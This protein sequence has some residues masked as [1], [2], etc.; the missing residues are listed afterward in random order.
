MTVHTWNLFGAVL[1]FLQVSP[2]V[3]ISR[4]GSYSTNAGGTTSF[5]SSDI[6]LDMS[7][8]SDAAY[9][10]RNKVT[11]CTDPQAKNK[12]L[13]STTWQTFLGASVT[14]EAKEAIQNK[15]QNMSRMKYA[16]ENL[17]DLLLPNGSTC[18]HYSHD[19]DRG[20]QVL[21]VRSSIH[22]Y[23]SVVYAGTDD[24]TTALMDGDILMSKF[25]PT[26]NTT[27]S[28]IDELKNNS[29][30]SRLF[31]QVPEEAHVHRGFNSA[32]FDSNHFTEVLECVTS[33]RLGGTCYG[34][35]EKIE[36]QTLLTKTKPYQL[37]TTGHSLGAADS[38]LL[39]AAL[40]LVFPSEKI[41][42]I[43]FGCPKIGNL[44]MSYWM[45]SL[46]PG[47]NDNDGGLEIFRFVNKLDLVPR[48]PD[49]IFFQHA[50]HTL[51]MS[52]GGVIR[53]YYNHIG[54]E[55][56]GYA[57]VSFGWGTEPYVLFPLALYAHHHK[58]YVDYLQDNA[59]KPDSSLAQQNSSYFVAEFERIDEVTDTGGSPI[60]E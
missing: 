58:R 30:F 33:A 35:A 25:G 3:S 13:V 46:Q 11:S 39:G 10:L 37:Y 4:L 49:L 15:Q 8:L 59:P 23:V 44:E 48:L 26:T 56:L 45:D 53:A 29:D 42:S 2:V 18:L 41:Q 57:G 60:A 22:R 40:H 27:S 34:A 32:V 28:D 51:Q 5:P 47:Q 14:D 24:F 36:R 38:I 20:T 16:Q 54:D 31:E 19:Y 50:G 7:T 17:F 1:T 9:Y 21:V 12:S 52:A 43:N 6:V 55:N